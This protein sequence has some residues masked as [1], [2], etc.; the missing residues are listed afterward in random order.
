[1]K[2]LRTFL[3]RF[4][5]P[6]V[7]YIVLCAVFNI[8]T[9]FLTIFSFAFIIP[10]LQML[11]GLKTG[12]YSYI[13][14]TADNFTDALVNNFY[15]YTGQIINEYGA[16]TALA[17]IIAVFIFMTVLRCSAAFFSEYFVQPLKNGVIRD[18]RNRMYDKIL[19][20]PIGYFTTARKGDIMSRLS[21]DVMEVENSVTS[22]IYSLVKYPLMIVACLAVMFAMSWQ[23]TVFV[24]LMLPVAGG[25]LALIGKKLKA[26]SLHQ[27]QVQG[28]ITSTTEESIGGLRVIKAFNAQSTMCRLFRSLTQ[29]FYRVSNS[30]GRRFSLAHPVSETL[31]TMA[32]C[33]TIWF[34][35]TLILNG[36]SGLDA[37]D[38]I[39]YIVTF[40]NIINPVKELSRT[41]YTVRKG[42]GAL[43]RIDEVL[44]AENPIKDPADPKPL[45]CAPSGDC[46]SIRFDRVTFRYPGSETDVLRDID[47]EIPAGATVA[48]VG[49]SGSGKSTLADM[50][51][52]FYDVDSGRITVNGTDI[53]SLRVADLRSAMGN[54][55][56]DAILFNDTFFNNIAFG[57]PDATPEQVQ[58]AARIANAHD[59]IE[60]TPDGYMTKVGDRGCRLS[61]GQRQRVS[62][63]RAVLKD[64]SI[65]ILDEATSAL[66]TESE[67]LVQEALEKLMKGRTTLVIAHRLSTIADADLICVMHEGRIVER[68]THR[69]LLQL[70]GHYRRLVEMQA[71][72]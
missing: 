68:G 37:A 64:P 72:G 51:P 62:I 2:E 69:E 4:A 47:L 8:L 49:Q 16:S 50:L 15:F 5:R 11:F 19:S 36:N 12:H 3:V 54:V 53:R 35:G 63:A 43:T 6:Y 55:N 56:Q 38:F 42:M 60:A 57:C 71:I 52:R 1:M 59:F 26:S 23:L 39:F 45:P 17:C 10:I 9:A 46:P 29:E 7:G 13:P 31:G 61:G 41:S 67:R 33:A 24:L 44:D 25:L 58:A 70:N 32:I 28:S 40:Y 21:S 27:L 14:L 30:V 65:L 22:S 34:G 18:I 66:D 48:L 20:L